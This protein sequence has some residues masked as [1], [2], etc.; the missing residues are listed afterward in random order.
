ML[1]PSRYEFA[2]VSPLTATV[3]PDPSIL[4]VMVEVVA[5]AKRSVP[6][7]TYWIQPVAPDSLMDATTAAVPNVPQVLPVS[8][9]VARVITLVP[10]PAPASVKLATVA[11]KVFG[12]KAVVPPLVLAVPLIVIDP[13]VGAVVSEVKVNAVLMVLLAWSDEVTFLLDGLVNEP[14]PVQDHDV[15]V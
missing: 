3:G 11:V 4:T 7:R 12:A 5:F 9:A 15:E 10:I 6:V 1:E 14:L 2:P 13:P 8:V